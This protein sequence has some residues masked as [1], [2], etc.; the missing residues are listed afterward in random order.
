MIWFFVSHTTFL[1]YSV[2]E[3]SFAILKFFHMMKKIEDKSHNQYI[4]GWPLKKLMA[5]KQELRDFYPQFCWLVEI[6]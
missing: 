4:Q 3:V 5:E 6:I 2:W 1:S